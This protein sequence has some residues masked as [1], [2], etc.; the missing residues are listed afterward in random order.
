MASAKWHPFCLGLNVGVQSQGAS[1][2]WT[3]VL[4]VSNPYPLCPQCETGIIAEQKSRIPSKQ[5]PCT[6]DAITPSWKLMIHC[7]C[8]CYCWHC[9][10]SCTTKYIAITPLNKI[11][12]DTNLKTVPEKGNFQADPNT[13]IGKIIAIS[14]WLD[15]NSSDK[16]NSNLITCYLLSFFWY[17]I[18]Q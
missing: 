13:Y 17:T 8:W 15:W 4:Q 10:P 9:K 18:M 3:L 5:Q 7:N 1:I 6:H 12:W 14:M 2:F 16:M 11:D